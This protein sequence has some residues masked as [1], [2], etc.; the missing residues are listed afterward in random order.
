M[1]FCSI[2]CPSLVSRSRGSARQ[3]TSVRLESGWNSEATWTT[4]P[5][6][7]S[8]REWRCRKRLSTCF[9]TNVP[10]CHSKK[11]GVI[12]DVQ[13]WLFPLNN[14]YFCSTKTRMY[15]CMHACMSVCMYACMRL[16]IFVFECNFQ[17]H[18]LRERWDEQG[19]ECFDQRV[20]TGASSGQALQGGRSHLL[21]V[22]FIGQ[23]L[24]WIF[25]QA[26]LALMKMRI[27]IN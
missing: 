16:Y 15:V 11:K 9:S 26:L 1:N 13:W 18:Q 7:F 5:T 8:S 22:V 25:L 17:G 10:R 19:Q 20:R 24:D 2:V 4:L 12:V 6:T 3:T 23:S 14:Y 27:I 21:W